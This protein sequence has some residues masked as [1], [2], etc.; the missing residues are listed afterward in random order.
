MSVLTRKELA[1][2]WKVAERTIIDWENQ[3]V[4]S[5]CKGI[6]KPMYALQH[7]MEL[8]GVTLDKMSPLER[9][10]LERQIAELQQ[11][12]NR[13]KVVLAKIQ[14]DATIA[15]FELMKGGEVS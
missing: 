12:N 13:M 6:P 3:K 5:R 15:N 10:R 2:R 11:E 1:A 8:E 7:V 9:R 14:H 4:L